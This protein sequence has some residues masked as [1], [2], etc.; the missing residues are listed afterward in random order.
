MKE[1]QLIEVDAATPFERGRQYGEQ[2][3]DKIQ[4]GVKNYRAFFESKGKTW[5]ETCEAA[6]LFVPDIEAAMPEVLEEA[7]GIAAGAEVPFEGLMVLNTRYELTN[8]PN[9][10]KECTTG[11]VLPEASS[12]QRTY[13]VKNWDYRPGVLDKIVILH[14]R[15]E[16][17]TR[18]LGLTEAGQMVREGFNSNGI[19]LCNNYIESIWDGPGAGIPVC[20]LRRRVLASK[21][22]DEAYSWLTGIKRSVSNNMLLVSGEGRAIDVEATPRGCDLLKPIAGILTH[23]NHF[24]AD[25]EKDRNTTWE[26]MDKG[27][28]VRLADLLYHKRGQIDAS[29][30]MECLKDHEYLP[31]AICNH[32]NNGDMTTMNGIM[33]VASMIVDFKELSAYICKGN[34]C[35]G[36]YK[37]YY[38]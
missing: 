22:F 13:M 30:L 14:I 23:A 28:A 20:F 11:A 12:D 26:K 9:K 3:K 27:R 19:G 34:P 16:T 33:T 4:A 25:P 36:E 6:M 15:D 21:T 7:R 32:D 38:I 29:Y 10:P 37:K 8:Y 17:G 18:I 1:F 24:I 5:E 35:T 2:A 31:H